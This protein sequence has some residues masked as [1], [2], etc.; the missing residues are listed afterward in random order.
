[1]QSKVS[2]EK[3]KTWMENKKNV[4]ILDIRPKEQRQEWYIPGSVHI[5]AYTRINEGDISVLDDVKFPEN[6]PVVTVCAAGR[7]STIA[8]NELRKKGIEAYSLT[9]GM[10]EWSTAWNIATLFF[11]KCEVVQFR[12][13]GKGCLSYMIISGNE[14]AIMD[15]SLPIEAYTKVLSDRQLKLRF[16]LETHIHADHLSRT[17]QLADKLQI[18]IYFPKQEK[19]SFKFEP[20]AHGDILKLANIS[21]KALHTPGHTLESTTYLIN[22]KVAFTGDTLFIDGIGRPDLKTSGEEAIQKA[23]LLYHSLQNLLELH[24]NTVVLPGHTS[25][26]VEFN[27]IPI[28]APL[29]Y[30]KQTVPMLHLSQ[31]E[32]VKTILER[33]P[34]TPSN[35]LVITESN[36]DGIYE[37]INAVDLEAGA[38]RCSVQ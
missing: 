13:T 22:D 9:G 3:L 20:V 28:Q 37:G 2:S 35:Y 14:S 19:I 24:D 32:F 6:V 33:I 1:M 30:I 25:K 21:F 5:D 11:E 31:D 29:S 26:P 7:T 38:N 27:D 34:P 4:F 23:K 8:A 18:P 15:A 16:V 36:I 17:K 12:R 10:K